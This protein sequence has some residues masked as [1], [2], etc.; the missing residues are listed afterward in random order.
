VSGQ[1]V[2]QLFTLRD[3]T[4][5]ADRL[6]RS[7]D[8]LREIG[9]RAVQASA[10]GC[11]DGPKPEV[12]AERFGTMLASRGMSC[13]ATHRPWPRLLGETDAELEF[14]LALGCRY[15]AVPMLPREYEEPGGYGRWLGEARPVAERFTVHGIRFGYHNHSHDFV[16]E[17]RGGPTRYDSLIEGGDPWLELEID[18]YWA[19][20]AGVDPVGLL[21]KCMGRAAMIHLKDREVLPG[22]GPVMAP[23]GEGNLDWPALVSLCRDLGTE[24]YIVEQDDCRRDPF[25]CLRSSFVYLRGLGVSA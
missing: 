17:V 4:G 14:H 21:R 5:T 12:T 16:R 9:Y 3:F 7:L 11:M 18:T 24:G 23:V 1:I 25:D 15:V 22:V 10:V 6:E 8:K 13:V 20:H 19:V 2:A